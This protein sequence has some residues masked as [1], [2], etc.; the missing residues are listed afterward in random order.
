MTSGREKP[1]VC[2]ADVC[3]A[4]LCWADIYWALLSNNMNR[5][6]FWL[7]S[8]TFYAGN[9][10]SYFVVNLLHDGFPEYCPG[11]SAWVV[12]RPALPDPDQKRILRP[13]GVASCAQGLNTVTIFPAWEQGRNDWLSRRRQRP[14]RG[15][16]HR[17]RAAPRSVAARRRLAPAGA[18]RTAAMVRTAPRAGRGQSC[19]RRA[20]RR[21]VRQN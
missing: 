12:T 5:A 18:R 3:W 6:S 17:A 2:W 14:P 20:P 13:L 4:D 19:W 21:G 7:N 8:R 15:L 11:L 1:D 10:P 16:R 9:T